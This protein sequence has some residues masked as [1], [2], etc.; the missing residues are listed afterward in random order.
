MHDLKNA[1]RK[2]AIHFVQKVGIGK[3][4]LHFDFFLVSL[5]LKFVYSR[6]SVF[7]HKSNHRIFIWNLLALHL[8]YVVPE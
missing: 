8:N 7:P 2:V 5:N 6:L 4:K 3:V 1:R